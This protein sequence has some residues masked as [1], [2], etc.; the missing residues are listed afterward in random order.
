[1][2]A[3]QQPGLFVDGAL[4]V[5]D[6]GAVGGAHLAQRGVRLRHHVGDAE[7]PADFDQ[8]AARDDHFAAFRQGVERQ[9]HGGGVVVDDD[10]GDRGPRAIILRQQLAKQTVDVDV[11]LTTLAGCEIE[12]QIG[13]AGSG[14]ANVIQGVL[15]QRSAS[16]I[17]VQDH[18][19]GV[20]HRT[21]RVTQRLPQAPLDRI[22]Q[23][24][25]RELHSL[26]VQPA[27]SDFVSQP[28][29]HRASR[30]GESNVTLPGSQ[31][32]AFRL[33]EQLVHRRQL[34]IEIRLGS[35]FHAL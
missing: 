24:G 28:R 4:V 25:D 13:I 3:Q 23:P 2:H 16:E 9:Q 6:A 1:M 11:A 22:R 26:R 31:S 29:Q 8:F 19:G 21:Q 17:G 18:A 12:L 10:G 32:S 5:G 15:R 14:L 20:D 7:R 27:S 35:S 33:A 34:A 30:V